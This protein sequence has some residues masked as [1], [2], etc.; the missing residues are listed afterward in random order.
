MVKAFSSK[1]LDD[2]EKEG[3]LDCYRW[4]M[5]TPPEVIKSEMM[6]EGT[7]PYM[8]IGASGSSFRIETVGGYKCM[9]IKYDPKI[10]NTQSQ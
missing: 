5:H 2:L 10:L 6:T 7:K 9:L 3:W 8:L 4:S 1:I